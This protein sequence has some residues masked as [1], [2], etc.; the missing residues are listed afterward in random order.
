M[1]R[2]KG[3]T[4]RPYRRARQRLIDT[5]A[6]CHI[7]G[8]PIDYTLPYGN[9]MAFVMDHVVPIAHGGHELAPSNTAAAHWVCNARKGTKPASAVVTIPRSREW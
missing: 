9:P 1:P 6:A 4:G 8:R 2:S 7:C 3:R 5:R